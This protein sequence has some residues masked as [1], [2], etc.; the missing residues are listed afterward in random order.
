[1]RR[2]G[3]L[4]AQDFRLLLR[5][6]IFWVISVSLLLI[7]ITVNWLIPAEGNL[8]DRSLVIYGLQLPGA[9]VEV[10]ESPAAV[11]ESV[12]RTGAVG[13]VYAAGELT[14]VHSGLSDQAVAALV[15]QLTPPPE[16]LPP[17]TVQAL[18]QSQRTGAQN[19]RLT[20]MFVSFEAVVLGF[21]MA[22]ILLLG[23]K[24]EGTL[25]AYR[26]SPGGA[27]AY[28][29]SKSLLFTL[30]GTIYALLMVV[31]TVGLAFNWGQF[32]LLTVLGCMLYT[33]LGLSLAIFFQDI[34]GWF[35]L[36]TLILALNMLPMVSFAAPSFSPG[37]M[38]LIP[39]YGGLFAYEEIL[40]P[41]GKALGGA[42]TTL[43]MEVLLAFGLC[44]T[45]VRRRLLS[46]E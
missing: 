35:F 28:V 31:T 2:I 7:V 19:L 39:S 24:Q 16:G 27:L 9:G 3:N 25:R 11:R 40:F 38:Q 12:E 41:T 37:W 1:M 45:L 30:V 44:L 46:A 5:N 20:P 8:G 15:S 14:V 23:E 17:I 32:I 6:A 42:L 10:A 36:A 29:L 4:L 21:L 26:V 34:S 18:R 43:G 13:L 22:A 33:L